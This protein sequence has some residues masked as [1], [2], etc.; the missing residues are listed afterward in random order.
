MKRIFLLLAAAAICLLPSCKPPEPPKITATDTGKSGPGAQTIKGGDVTMSFAPDGKPL[1]FTQGNSSNMLHAKN[2]GP[3]FYM[4][5]GSGPD[6]KNIPFTSA[7]SKDGRLILTADDK[8]RVTLAVNAGRRHISFNLEK[9]ENVPKDTEP[10]LNFQVNFQGENFQGFRPEFVSFNYMCLNGGGFASVRSYGTASWPYLWQRCDLDPLGGFAFFVPENDDEHNE[11]LLRIWTEEP[12][13]HPKVEGKWTYEKAKA[14]VED[15]KSKFTDTHGLTISAEKPGDLDVL[16]DYAKKL[17][18]NRLYLH[19]DT[20]RGAYFVTERH[21]LSVNK[22]VFPRGEADLKAFQDKLKANGMDS[23]LHTL[24]YGFGRVGTEYIGKGKK[25]DRRLAR[26]GKGKLEKPISATDTVILF[27]PDPKLKYPD[28]SNRLFTYNEIL[29]GDEIV[30]CTFTNTDQE[31]WTLTDCQRGESPTSHEAGTEIIGIKKAYGMSYYPSSFTDLPEITGKEYAEFFNRMGIQHN[32]FDGGE[33]HQDVPW[34]FPKWTMFVYQ[35]TDHP[36]TS[37]TSGGTPNPWDLV[38]RFKSGGTEILN[39]RGGGQAFLALHNIRN[40]RLATSPIENHFTLAQA[41]AGN[42]TGMGFKKPEPMYGI[43]PNVIQDHGLA[44]MLAGQYSTWREVSTKLTPELRKQIQAAYYKDMTPF[45]IDPGPMV[46]K[47]NFEARKTPDGYEV[48]PFCV[49]ERGAEDV[50]WRSIMEYGTLMPR[51][52]VGP[53]MRLRLENPF[54]RQTPQF[55]IRILDGYT[56]GFVAKAAEA[57]QAEVNKDL[58]GYN[59]GAGIERKQTPAPAPAPANPAAGLILQPK[60]AQMTNTGKYQFADVGEA[61]EI[62][63]DNTTKEAPPAA[64]GAKPQPTPA[65]VEHYQEREF[66]NFAINGNAQNSPGLALTVTGD[67]SGAFLLVRIGDYDYVVPMD[68]TGRKDIFI[69]LGEVAHSVGRWGMRPHTRGK[70]YQPFSSVS[71]GFC[72]VPVNTRAMA[73]VENLRMV[74][75]KPSSIKNPVIHAGAGTLSIKGEVKTGQYLW[76]QG[77]DSV[78]VYDFNW[79]LLENLPVERKD[80]EVDK[81]F[82]DYW[83]DGECATPPPWFDVQFIAKGETTKIAN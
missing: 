23:M 18:V 25:T 6:A 77:G 53:Q 15:W 38:Y 4:T 2:P 72:R 67:G 46:A 14:W 64:P 40:R 3:G 35:N 55:I 24:C 34:G 69:P 56:D 79:H 71:I 26:W 33:C 57:P 83:I 75:E 12:I 8:T 51:Q 10:V 44:E 13:P 54:G 52:Y 60:A 70:V 81:G 19:T 63:L 21:P 41:A 76:Y 43:F 28:I 82:T 66:P 49:M 27:R 16:I 5:L 32:E 80:F 68:F 7:E 20:W 50:E 30:T 37:N 9:I 11:G 59:L 74:G 62:S 78:G 47:I 42:S 17:K 48:Q 22:A 58:E 39:K 65:P 36:M 45:P 61:L 31:V 29:I 73:L 1:S